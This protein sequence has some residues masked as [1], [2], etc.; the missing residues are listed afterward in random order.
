MKRHEAFSM[1]EVTIALAIV[2]FGLIAIM[3]LLP[4]G[5]AQVRESS[6]EGVATNILSDLAAEIS[7]LETRTNQTRISLQPG[8]S[9]RIFYNA[10]GGFLGTNNSSVDAVFVAT[11]EVRG[12]DASQGIPPSVYLTV[13]WPA[14]ST[15]PACLA[16]T[17][18][19]LDHDP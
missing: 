6:S 2:A 12:R 17:I 8:H 3:G 16:E 15:N 11:W 4:R 9:G 7:T 5:V 18:L 19:A 13:G 1:V 10:E 14:A